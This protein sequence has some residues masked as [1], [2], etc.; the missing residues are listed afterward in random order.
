MKRLKI[1]NR[2]VGF[3][4]VIPCFSE[5]AEVITKFLFGY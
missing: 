5:A 4:N 2:K 3:D 1:L